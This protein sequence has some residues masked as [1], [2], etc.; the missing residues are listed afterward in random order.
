MLWRQ[1]ESGFFFSRT[2]GWIKRKLVGLSD[3][4]VM[5][6]TSN[7]ASFNH[8]R[9]TSARINANTLMKR[10]IKNSITKTK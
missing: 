7:A 2:E 1:S 8:P 3:D 10:A 4:A 5:L 9:S 6:A